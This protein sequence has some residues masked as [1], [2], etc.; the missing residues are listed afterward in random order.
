MDPRLLDVAVGLSGFILFTL[1]LIG[2]PIILPAGIAYILAIT[3][4]VV[5]M[6]GAGVTINRHIT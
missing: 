3:C 5:L 4:F 1:L 6:S 2:L